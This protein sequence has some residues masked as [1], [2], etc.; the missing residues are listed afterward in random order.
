MPE[1]V[2]DGRSQGDG[3]AIERIQICGRASTYLYSKCQFSTDLY[4]CCRGV[5][6]YRKHADRDGIRSKL[7][8]AQPLEGIRAAEET[9]QE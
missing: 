9:P 5:G 8:L 2:V 1:T 6:N 3:K 7:C 4:C